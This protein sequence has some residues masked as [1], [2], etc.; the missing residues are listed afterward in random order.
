ME[1]YIQVD[2]EKLT[3]FKGGA[4]REDKVGK[5]RYDLIPCVLGALIKRVESIFVDCGSY[6]ASL[7]DLKR[8]SWTDKPNRYIDTLI[9][10]IALR[11][12]P[13]EIKNTDGF[14]T[15]RVNF[16]SWTWGL[17]KMEAD[18]S[19]HYEFGAQAHGI[20]NWK[21]GI[22]ISGGERGGSF[23]DSG[24][25]HL[26]HW[27]DVT[28]EDPKFQSNGVPITPQVLVTDKNGNMV[29]EHPDVAFCWNFICAIYNILKEANDRKID[30]YE[31]KLKEST[32]DDGEL[33][34]IDPDDAYDFGD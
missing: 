32:A 2:N 12:A 24:M 30:I 34:M 13:G 7:H 14:I 20:D 31:E 8:V 4:L 22:P 33:E 19:H 10:F 26:N 9:E 27:I 1:N 15:K 25:R 11:Y 28:F 18:L 29:E 6:T 3:S 23:T 17:N 5:G 16:N 21:K